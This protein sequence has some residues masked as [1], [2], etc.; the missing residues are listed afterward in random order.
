MTTPRNEA[1]CLVDKV[2]EIFFKSLKDVVNHWA[3]QS[4]DK[5]VNKGVLKGYEDGTFRPDE[6][7]TRAEACAVVAK[8]DGYNGERTYY[9][10]YNDF[11]NYDWF[12]NYVGYC[13]VHSFV[14]GY[15]NQSF[16]PHNNL[17]RAEAA[18]ILCLLGRLQVKPE[19][20]GTRFRD[21]PKSHWAIRFV[22]A[23][24]DNGYIKGY[25][26]N[27]F[28]PSENITR[29]EFITIIDRMGLLDR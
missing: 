24:V 29:A 3:K 26:D 22:N 18:K 14:L 11:T 17:T 7:I 28:R 13:T 27:T 2:Q 25:E 8:A 9:A 12:V 15:P 20:K 4:I 21:V 16:K 23:L 10:S 19:I 5:A 1:W 6:P